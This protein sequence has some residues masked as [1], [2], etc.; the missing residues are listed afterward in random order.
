MSF[1]LI[2][3]SKPSNHLH[4]KSIWLLLTLTED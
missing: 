4:Y 1:F 2:N 3:G